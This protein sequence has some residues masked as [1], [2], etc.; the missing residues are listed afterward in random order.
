MK[1]PR[2]LYSQIELPRIARLEIQEQWLD[3]FFAIRSHARGL[4]IWHTMDPDQPDQ[5]DDKQKAPE[6]ESYSKLKARLVQE[7]REEN[8]SAPSEEAIITLYAALSRDAEIK[9]VSYQERTQKERAMRQQIMSTVHP[10]IYEAAMTK[11]AKGKSSHTLRQLL[12]ELQVTLGIKS[13][14]SKGIVSNAYETVLEEAKQ[15]AIN[16][17]IWYSKWKKHLA[18][19]EDYNCPEVQG[20]FAIRRFLDAVGVRFDS[21]W[22]DMRL[23]H[24]LMNNNR[25]HED[26]PS[27]SEVGADFLDNLRGMKRRAAMKQYEVDVDD[28]SDM[29]D[30]AVAKPRCPCKRKK[31]PWPPEECSY[32]QYA[33]TGTTT[34]P[35]KKLSETDREAIYQE[36]GKPHWAKL[37]QTLEDKGWSIAF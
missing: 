34:R 19:A 9:L 20:F 31:H 32:L 33:L 30:K 12:R 27:L 28:G 14:F 23:L 22:A 13:H 17:E 26:M 21:Q 3:W 11:L 36:I 16:P 10:D 24:I 1:P 8:R 25:T 6:I 18:R 37:L 5:E 7:A 35:I 4:E 29:T 15:G 2:R